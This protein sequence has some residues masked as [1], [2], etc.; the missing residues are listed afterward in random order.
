LTGKTFTR[1]SLT[2]S[3]NE[4]VNPRNQNVLYERRKIILFS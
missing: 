3:P 2:K 1:V 4:R